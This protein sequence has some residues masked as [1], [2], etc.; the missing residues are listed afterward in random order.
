MTKRD[1]NVARRSLKFAKLAANQKNGPVRWRLS[2]ADVPPSHP[3]H[4]T[5][6]SRPSVQSRHELISHQFLSTQFPRGVWCA[7]YGRLRGHD[8]I[9]CFSLSGAH[10]NMW[11]ASG[12]FVPGGPASSM[13]RVAT[14]FEA[15]RPANAIGA[16]LTFSAACDDRDIKSQ[17]RW[18]MA[19]L[20]GGEASPHKI[21]FG[22][23]SFFQ[24][25]KSSCNLPF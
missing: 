10:V 17:W 25:P 3:S 4:A 19:R 13:T 11:G 15:G 5:T 8:K 23:F 16:N 24:I 12:G 21:T 7:T 1:E 14:I 22:F 9:P 6:V 18:S 2:E 20:W